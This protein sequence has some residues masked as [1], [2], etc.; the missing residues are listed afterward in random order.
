MKKFILF[1][2]AMTLCAGLAFAQQPT[3]KNNSAAAPA[4]KEVKTEQKQHCGKCP[5]HANAN[6]NANKE[7]A[8]ATKDNTTKNN[9]TQTCN[10]EKTCNK[11]CNKNN[12][13]QTCNKEK[14][15]NKACNKNN[16]NTNNTAT[17]K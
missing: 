6:A 2:A 16:A 4:K 5:H 12:A 15:C 10:K 17:K 1:A 8:A 7:T 3:K 14:P 11:A 9:A 13:T